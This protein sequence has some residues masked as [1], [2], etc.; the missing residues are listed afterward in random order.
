MAGTGRIENLRPPWK[1]G[2]PSPNP[3][4]RPKRRPITEA[5]EAFVASPE[6]R[7]AIQRAVRSQMRVSGKHPGMAVFVRETLEGKLAE[8][9]EVSGGL[10]LAAR[11]ARA[12]AR[13]KELA[14]SSELDRGRTSRTHAAFT[15]HG[16]RQASSPQQPQ[17]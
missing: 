15:W 8:R 17:Q 3:S 2:D 5:L 14:E 9:V 12:R 6:G 16:Q 13:V 11:V 10:E 7:K 1:K 4:G